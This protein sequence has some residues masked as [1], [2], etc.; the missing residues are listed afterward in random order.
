MEVEVIDME[1]GSMGHHSV[2]NDEDVESN[3]SQETHTGNF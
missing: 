1:R 3:G 2:A